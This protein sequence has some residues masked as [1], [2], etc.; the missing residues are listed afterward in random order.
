[1]RLRN[2]GWTPSLS[3]L[4]PWAPR[5]LD[6]RVPLRHHPLPSP[7][8]RSSWPRRAALGL[9]ALVVATSGPATVAGAY[10][11]TASSAAG[12]ATSTATSAATKSAAE[13]ARQRPALVA[14]PTIT[15]SHQVGSTLRVDRGR[16]TGKPTR[17][18]FAWDA[19]GRA[20]TGGVTGC[21][22]IGTGASLKL[23]PAQ[24]GR[25]VRARVTATNAAGS[26]AVPTNAGPVVGAPALL[27]APTIDGVLRAGGSITASPGE[28]A[29]STATYTYAWRS[30]DT[31]PGAGCTPLTGAVGERLVIPVDTVGRT[32]T[33]D[34]TASNRYGTRTASSAPRPAVE[35][36]DA[37]AR[38]VQVTV[39][40]VQACALTADHLV[41]CWGADAATDVPQSAF[42][43]ISAGPAHTC[44]ITTGGTARCWGPDGYGETDVPTDLGQVTTISSGDNYTCAAGVR[45]PTARCW[46]GRRNVSNFGQFTVPDDLGPV[47]QVDAGEIHTCAVTT[48]GA[49]RC[50]GADFF[51]RST[52][53]ADLG[54]VR[55]VVSGGPVSCAVTT[56]GSARCW[57]DGDD[58]QREAPADLGPVRSLDAGGSLGTAHICAVTVAGETRCWGDP[59][60][61]EDDVLD[62][63][64]DLGPVDSVAVGVASGCVVTTAGG[65]RCWGDNRWGQSDVPAELRP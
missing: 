38:V 7:A 12:A 14:R 33:V 27:A 16:W 29:G 62:V 8:H 20:A 51:G 10:G 26:R 43:S 53:P 46:G 28:W 30:C 55:S 65:V 48:G 47:S 13:A 41:R 37:S 61:R 42:T 24:L 15:G 59:T 25:S 6:T 40:S 11:A 58:G 1:M 50:W 36:R 17:Y 21:R 35:A 4:T 60:F 56:A 64:Q 34:V 5:E 57:G 19:C 31:G 52:P 39:G 44:G 45:T 49:A 9:M 3:L 63:P 22:Q 32:I 2:C 23:G 18:A 54:T